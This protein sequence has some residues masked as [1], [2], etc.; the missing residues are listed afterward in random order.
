MVAL[1]FLAERRWI[2][3]G[4]AA[5]ASPLPIGQTENVYG[6]DGDDEL[7]GNSLNNILRGGRGDDLFLCGLGS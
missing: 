6:G 4:R 7:V 5:K 2:I 3:Y 1:S